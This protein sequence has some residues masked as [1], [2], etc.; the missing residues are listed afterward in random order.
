LSPA[1]QYRFLQ[2]NPSCQGTGALTAGGLI[3]YYNTRPTPLSREYAVRIEYQRDGVPKAFIENPKLENLADG[4]DI[5]HI[6]H[7]PTR[8]CL[9]LPRTKEWHPSLRIDETFVPWISTWL[10]YFE[11]WL[12]SGEWRGG[13]AHPSISDD[14]RL[15][16]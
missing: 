4:R 5:P 10:Y 14:E 13:G 2:R 9:Y 11:D 6:Y 3:W 12:A 16:G 15:Q 1:L 7:D 8:L